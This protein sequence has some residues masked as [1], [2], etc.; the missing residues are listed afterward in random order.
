MGDM[1]KMKKIIL[2]ILGCL[3]FIA[4]AQAATINLTSDTASG[5]LESDFDQI[6]LLIDGHDT[7]D[8]TTMKANI[9]LKV[10]TT[11]IDTPAEL[12]SVANLGAYAS[13]FLSVDT[14]SELLE[15]LDLEVGTDF[16]SVAAANAAFEGALGNPSTNGYVLSSLT[17]GTRSWIANGAGSMTYPDAGIPLSTG[18]AWGTS[19]SIITLMQALD[20]QTWT[21]ANEVTFADG[22][23][24]TPS[25]TPTMELEDSDAPGTDKESAKIYSNYIDGADGAENHDLFFQVK[26]GGTYATIFQF[27]ESDDQIEFLKNTTLQ[28]GDII[29]S[30]RANITRG[31]FIPIGWTDITDGGSDPPYSTHSTDTNSRELKITTFRS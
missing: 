5:M 30:E 17:D 16:Y 8:I 31:E 2:F 10:S 22:Y 6:K 1:G 13:D 19:Y 27:D 15:L 12:E 24:V 25:A 29:E 4:Q 21:F 23:S 28:P 20:D 26:Q 11:A 7:G 9:A 14:K 3:L 18:S